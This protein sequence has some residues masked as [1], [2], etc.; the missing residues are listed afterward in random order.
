[1]PDTLV[2]VTASGGGTRATALALSVLRSMGEIRTATGDTFADQVDIVSSVSGG[3]VAAAYF[4]MHGSAGLA[5]LERDFV[6][7]DG[8]GALALNGLNPVSLLALASPERERIDVLIDYL[9]RTLFDGATFDYFLQNRQPPY[10]ILNAADMVEGIP[11]PFTQYTMDLLCSD[12]RPMGIATAVAASAAF[13]VALSPV[14][15]KNYSVP[16]T[17]H[18]AAVPY[19]QWLVKAQETKWD[20]NP[21]RV[22]L[23]RTAATYAE[24]DKGYIHLLDGGI[25]DNLGI[26]EPY[27]LL[28]T[29]DVSPALLTKLQNGELKKIVFVVIN[30]RSFKPSD[31]D[32]APNTPGVISMLL[33]SINSSIDRASFGAAE[34]LRAL[35]KESWAADARKMEAAYREALVA[36]NWTK[37]AILKSATENMQRLAENAEFLT[38]ELDAIPDPSCRRKMQSIPTSWTLTAGQI[39]ATLA[40]GRALFLDNANLPK[41][42]AMLGANVTSSAANHTADACAN[43]PEHW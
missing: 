34:R 36:N 19:P 10:L 3:S 15:L 12:L 11:F 40:M 14:T 42:A 31:L 32:N 38:V 41:V 28:T 13:P 22:A 39:D 16:D 29:T 25:A 17:P 6:R 9:N 43:L 5:T 7:K 27:R 30:A 33:A 26:A 2:I 4:A 8:M 21:S 23:G 18:C 24:G 1:M 20:Q 37:A 35:F